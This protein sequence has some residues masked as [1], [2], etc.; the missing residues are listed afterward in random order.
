MKDN[1]DYIEGKTINARI[2]KHENK[3]IMTFRDDKHLEAWKKRYP[4]KTIYLDN[5]FKVGDSVFVNLEEYGTVT[6]E[7]I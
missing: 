6:K 4:N 7:I 3:Y 5:G 2:S 1:R